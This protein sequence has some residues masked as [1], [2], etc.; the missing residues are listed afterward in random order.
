MRGKLVICREYAEH[1]DTERIVTV[2]L[3]LLLA[4]KGGKTDAE[5]GQA[6]TR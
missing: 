5:S 3:R 2:L 6:D 1:P 4:G